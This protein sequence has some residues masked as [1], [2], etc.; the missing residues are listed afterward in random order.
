MKIDKQKT[1]FLLGGYDLEMVTI[2]EL[3]DKNGIT[4]F[5]NNLPWGAKLSDYKE[6]IE[7][8][9]ENTTFYAIELDIDYTL[10]TKHKLEIID[11]HNELVDNPT[12]LEQVIEL[13]E[14]EDKLSSKTKRYYKLVSANDRDY[15]SGLI[16]A[17]ATD[18]EIKYIRAKD[19]EAQGVIKEDEIRAKNDV[20]SRKTSND[21]VTICAT[22]DR[23]S[24]ISDCLYFET[25]PYNPSRYIIYN[26]EE[27]IFYGF[28]IAS[29]RES[30]KQFS[31]EELKTYNGRGYFGVLNLSAEKIRELKDFIIEK[32]R[33]I[34][35]THIF[36]FP[37]RFDKHL[38]GDGFSSEFEFYKKDIEERVNIE[39]LHK[40]L[41][42]N[43]WVYEKFNIEN[44]SSNEMA[45]LYSE[46]AYFYDYV[47]DAL[48]NLEEFSEDAIS[49][50][51]RKNSLEGGIF[52]I[53][54]KKKDGYEAKKYKL[55]IDGITLRV[56]STG[57]AILGIELLNR[58]YGSF[59]DILRI[60]DYG[61]RVYPQYIGANCSADTKNTFLANYIRVEDSSGNE[62]AK[63]DFNYKSYADTRVGS[64][65]LKI[66]GTN[67][68]TQ[69]KCRSDI[70]SN[71]N[72]PYD[73][74]CK[75][76]LRD[77]FYIQPS[78]DDRMF[79]H[80]WYGDEELAKQCGNEKT[81]AYL[82]NDKWYEYVF[83]DNDEATVKNKKFK[84][85]L[86]SQATYTRWSGNNTLY[87]VTRY[88]FV[89]LTDRSWF[90]TNILHPHMRAM[91][92]QMTILLLALR[93]SVLR[94]S[95]EIASLAS[96]PDFSVDKTDKVYKKY[97]LFYNRLY[98]K[99]VTHQDQGIELYDIALKQM[100]IPEHIEKLDNKFPKLFE[101][102]KLKESEKIEKLKEE[103]RELEEEN[104][105]QKRVTEHLITWLG[106]LFIIPS[107]IFAILSLD[108][109]KEYASVISVVTTLIIGYIFT[110]IL[111]KYYKNK[112][113]NKKNTNST[114]EYIEVKSKS[115]LVFVGLALLSFLVLVAIV[116]KNDKSDIQDVN[117]TKQPVE[118]KIVNQK[119]EESSD[120]KR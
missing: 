62:I 4:Y 115:K 103:K 40:K 92:F 74:K 105:K 107:L 89:A 46:F 19:R 60:N 21:I 9:K 8:E 66:L 6:D 81:K 80:C 42:D 34:I 15:I 106:G 14:I 30:F 22:I 2:K 118:V 96:L 5:D 49:N 75:K 51:Y 85:K 90:A 72:N 35:S 93:T 36:M 83:V 54:I 109:F 61:R 25:T 29:L 48:Y 116:F 98:F 77:L 31:K 69:C 23:F 82:K 65:I 114:K 26:D 97:L 79:V 71:C 24:A 27:I 58:D 47:R 3:L 28:N 120:T 91:Y 44:N 104:E 59:R 7:K 17:G 45:A 88:S 108:A 70:D 52:E 87:G 57:V 68:F 113:F 73:D 39:S 53:D 13:L 117:I 84:K 63:E 11:H 95:D 111:I 64:H 10:P 55:E 110:D 41:T 102:A 43:S 33:E 94:F 38:D 18:S 99:E 76:D 12:S 56:F 112:E 100:K 20:R 86:L 78:L 119:K 37:F 32:N 16:C 67:I 50:F 101:Y 1:I